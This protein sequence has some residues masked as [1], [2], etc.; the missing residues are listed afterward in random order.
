[1][2]IQVTSNHWHRLVLSFFLGLFVLRELTYLF[3]E[4]KNGLYQFLIY[5]PSFLV[6]LWVYYLWNKRKF[7]LAMRMELEDQHQFFSNPE[8]L[9]RFVNIAQLYGFYRHD[10]YKRIMD[11]HAMVLKRDW[12]YFEDPFPAFIKARQKEPHKLEIRIFLKNTY[13]RTAHELHD[14]AFRLSEDLKSMLG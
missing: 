13:D 5:F 2:Q 7:S 3:D 1:M 10:D 9:G 6:P 14:E 12:N 8:L 11:Q 4:P